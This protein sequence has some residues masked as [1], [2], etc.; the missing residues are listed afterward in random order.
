M[1]K[2]ISK[3]GV[4]VLI[5]GQGADERFG[6]YR[7]QRYPELFW[8][9]KKFRLIDASKIY[10]NSNVSAKYFIKYLLDHTK[11]IFGII[12]FF[13]MSSFLKLDINAFNNLIPNKSN[14]GQ[15]LQNLLFYSDHL[16][17]RNSIEVRNPF[18]DFRFENNDSEYNTKFTKF[19][20]RQNFS[21]IDK[22]LNMSIVWNT[23][24][25]GFF[26]P[27]YDLLINNKKRVLDLY[28]SFGDR[29]IIKLK[30]LNSLANMSEEEDVRLVY[31]IISS[32]L[33]LRNL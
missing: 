21:K 8:G 10:F 16:S 24:K 13:K 23:D 17:M 4:K 33:W 3:S 7:I 11:I 6:G 30:K 28:N 2:E 22:E 18:M 20:L 29:K 25:L 15:N 5:E 14:L 12:Y 19:T 26:T 9:V 32:E 27:M 1:Y 31:R